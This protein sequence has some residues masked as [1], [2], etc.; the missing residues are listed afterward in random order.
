MQQPRIPSHPVDPLFVN[1]WSP[2][3]FDGSQM[4]E[5]DLKTILEAA[6]WAP[7]AYN[8]QPWRFLYALRGDRNWDL[9]VGLLN[10]FNRTWADKASALVFLLS[11]TMMPG[12]EG[13][14]ETL[15]RYHSFDAGAA[16]AQAALQAHAL[17]YHS[18]AMAGILAERVR[19]ELKVSERFKIEI[20][21]AV[22]RQSDPSDLPEELRERET[23]SLR[24]PLSEI[25][26]A[27]AFAG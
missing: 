13:R 12:D 1:R 5:L 21:I 11:D 9:F 8:V 10:P 2:R 27:G 17:G 24:K 18:H 19:S 14:D 20:G 7:S 4:P 6:R 26:R 16:W 3:A 15:S 23:P 22:G 25:A